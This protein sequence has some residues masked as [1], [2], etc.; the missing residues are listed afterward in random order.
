MDRMKTELRQKTRLI[1]FLF[2]TITAMPAS[3][4]AQLV[5]TSPSNYGTQS[6]G[7]IDAFGLSATGGAPPYTWTLVSGTLP[8]GVSIRT[9]LPGFLVG[10]ASSAALIG[11]ATTPGTLNFRVRVTDS[12]FTTKE[13]DCTIK[14]ST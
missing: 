14:I 2:L 7:F 11:V 1:V 9:D 13:Q 8:D 10:G 5:I 3:A 4:Q 12:A 6:V